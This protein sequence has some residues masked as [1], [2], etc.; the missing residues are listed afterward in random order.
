MK[1]LLVAADRME[2]AGILAR[3]AEVR[4]ATVRVDFAREARV[5][6][7]EMLL[8]ANGAGWK[9]AGAAVDAAAGFGADVIVSTGFCGALED[10]I[11]VA[12]VVS[13]TEVAGAGKRW[14][15]AAVAARRSGV[16]ASIDHVAQT[17][18]EKRKLGAGGAC[19]VEMEAAAVA[20]RAAGLGLP[21]YCVRV[22]T[23][24]ACETM[25]NDLNGALRADGHFD[26]MFIL[27]GV[28]RHPT[29]R[30]PELLRLRR[31]A[32]R[33]AQALGEFIVGCRF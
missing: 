20:E 6:A 3:A 32:I 19:A 13:G 14:P 11:E 24:L 27:R 17:A 4:Q 21:F 28:L 33:A 25:E 5:G 2:F 9:R 10:G 16:I 15:C 26:T 1:I 23:D 29:V 12:D 30:L 22:V 31:R 8:V 7:H 18:L